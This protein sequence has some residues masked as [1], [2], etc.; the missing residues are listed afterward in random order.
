MIMKEFE[1]IHYQ[2]NRAE[3]ARFQAIK[4]ELGLKHNSEVFR[5]LLNAYQK[6][7]KSDD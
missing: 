4:A 2:M 1:L 5:V 6:E 3:T 7:D